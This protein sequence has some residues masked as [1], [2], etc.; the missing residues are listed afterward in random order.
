MIYIDVIESNKVIKKL[1]VNGYPL[2]IEVNDKTKVE[3]YEEFNQDIKLNVLTD[4]PSGILK[5]NIDSN[6]NQKT[7][8]H[9]YVPD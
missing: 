2:H 9:V 5:Y 7:F 6:F 8:D 3:G 4:E 1:E